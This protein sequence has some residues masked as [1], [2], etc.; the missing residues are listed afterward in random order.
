[1]TMGDTKCPHCDGT[2]QEHAPSCGT[3]LPPIEGTIDIIEDLDELK[4]EPQP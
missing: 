3:L 1:M 2:T 4:P